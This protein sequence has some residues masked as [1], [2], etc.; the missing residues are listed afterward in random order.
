MNLTKIAAP[1]F[2][3]RIRAAARW[4]H[5]G[6]DVQRAQLQ[7]LLH[8]ARQTAIGQRYGFGAM[9]SYEQFAAAVPLLPYP[10]IRPWVMEMAEGDAIY[11]GPAL[12]GG[13]P[14]HR[15]HPTA[16]ANIFR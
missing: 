3:P 14:S 15:A 5:D 9:A 1:Y 6:E 13:S 8:R 11:S 10:D 16:K 4:E 7:W 2:A 12:H